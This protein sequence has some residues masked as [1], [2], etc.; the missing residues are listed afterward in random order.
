MSQNTCAL[1]DLE[2]VEIEDISVK[3]E[4]IE[5][6]GRLQNERQACSNCGSHNVIFIGNNTRNFHLPPTGSKKAIL[7]VQSRRNQCKE[8]KST[9][10][11][12]AP[13]AD[14]KQRMTKSFVRYA[15]ELLR[16][17]TI[18]DV[19]DHLG[20]SWDVI[21]DLHKHYL[22]DKYASIPL[23][24]IK[25]ISIDEFSIAKGHKYMTIVSDVTSGQILHAVEGRKKQDIEPF[26]KEL[27]KK[28]KN[29]RLYPWI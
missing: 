20:V 26:L 11:P 17:G 18:K 4:K 21:K 13:F 19:A 1:Y 24:D 29:C 22:K 3:E 2:G 9:W 16:F 8:C 14:G 7:Y 6:F 12:Q 25:Y 5:V 10:W 28:V 23:E 27:K 15:L